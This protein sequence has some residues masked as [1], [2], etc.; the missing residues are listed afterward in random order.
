[1]FRWGRKLGV[2]GAI[3]R[4][5]LAAV[6]VL[7]VAM[8]GCGGGGG[9]APAADA[10]VPSSPKP[11]GTPG[12]PDSD[13]LKSDFVTA[14]SKL[15]EYR[16]THDAFTEDETLLGSDFPTDLTVKEGD[17]TSF[18]IAAYDNQGIRYVMRR[19]GPDTTRTCDPPA[20]GACPGGEW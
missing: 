8:A 2:D 11:S 17:K 10:T 19:D 1:M 9:D 13:Q 4:V 12:L 15:D 7:L 14:A 5:A 16:L 6:I 3:A 20:A 18:Y